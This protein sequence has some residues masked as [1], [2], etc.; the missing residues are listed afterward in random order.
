RIKVYHQLDDSSVEF[1]EF[2][3]VVD[4]V[5]TAYKMLHEIV[6]AAADRVATRVYDAGVRQHQMN[7]PDVQEVVGQL[8]DEEQPLALALNAGA[9]EIIFADR[10]QLLAAQCLEGQRVTQ[11]FSA[12]A[13]GD[14]LG[15]RRHVRQLHGALDL[16]VARENL[17]DECRAGARQ[18]DDENRIRC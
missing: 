10:A 1:T 2:R 15:E 11:L 6:K 16:R 9:R 13:R 5:L 3:E 7:E 12:G 4:K 18:A 14:A 17:L 8:V